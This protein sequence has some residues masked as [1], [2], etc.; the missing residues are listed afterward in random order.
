MAE[1]PTCLSVGQLQPARHVKYTEASSEGKS[2]RASR[3]VMVRAES[4]RPNECNDVILLQVCY[5]YQRWATVAADD[6]N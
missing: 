2:C 4:N 6:S 5:W 3:E 1:R